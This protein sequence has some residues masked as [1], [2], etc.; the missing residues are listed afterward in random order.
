MQKIQVALSETNIAIEAGGTAQLVVTLA[1]HQE[2]ADRLMLEVEGLDVEWYSIPVS[3]VNVAPG[4]QASER[5]LF[6]VARNSENLADAYPFLVRVKAMETGEVGVAQAILTVQ[7]FDL[8]QVDLN[9]KRAVATFLRPINEFETIVA[10][11]GNQER[12]FDLYASDPDDACAYEFDTDRISLRPGQ[13]AHI[14]LVTRPRTSAVLG[15]AQLYGFTV[16]VRATNDAYVSASTHG[17]LEKRALISPLLGIFLILLTFS[18]FAAWLFWPKPPVEMKVRDFVATPVNMTPGQPTP[19]PISNDP[20]RNANRPVFVAY[21]QKVLLSWDVTPGFKQLII[22]QRVGTDGAD[23]PDP[24]EQRNPVGSIT[25]EPKHPVTI[26]TLILRGEHQ[27]EKIQ[28]LIVQV[29]PPPPVQ[30]PRILSFS[31][32]PAVI[33]QGEM[34]MLSWSS[35]GAEKIIL[36]PGNY[37]VS[38]FEQTRQIRLDE[39]TTFTLR[40]FS[41]DDKM[42]PALSTTKVRVVP[43]DVCI[44]EIRGF[45]VVNDPVY[46]GDKVRLR[47]STAYARSVRIDSDKGPAVGV[48]ASPGSG[49]IEVP[50]PITEP[51]TFTLTATDSADKFVTKQITIT[52]KERPAQLPEPETMPGEN[53]PP[54]T[55]GTTS[56]GAF[57]TP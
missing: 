40:A 11:H 37:E 9:P 42:A 54:N 48:V 20:D 5:I 47:W 51:T 49:T 25:V 27:P 36:D 32:T 2:T 33:H 31:A 45:R 55:T 15:S 1:N 3:A 12:T 7:P 30:K 17:Q 56:P 19:R 16:N 41:K 29:G 6:K 28:R 18:G 4:A 13:A 35:T 14:P 44:A 21:G 53:A 24:G 57:S 23:V 10:N 43:R 26:Y 39:D 34:V 38:R 46:I 22:K 52:P 50:M 8:L